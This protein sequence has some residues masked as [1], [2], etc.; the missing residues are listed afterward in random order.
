MTQKTTFCFWEAWVKTW[1]SKSE[2]VWG[3]TWPDLKRSWCD[4]ETWPNS[5]FLT[6]SFTYLAI[7]TQNT[8][9]WFWEA[10]VKTWVSK[11]E[12]VWGWTWPDPKKS[13][14]DLE[15]WPTS[16]F[17]NR[18][19][20]YLATV[21]QKATF[22][23][24]RVIVVYAM[25]HPWL[26]LQTIWMDIQKT[27]FTQRF[28]TN[29]HYYCKYRL[30]FKVAYIWKCQLWSLL[31]L[32]HTEYSFGGKPAKRVLSTSLLN[33]YI[34]ILKSYLQYLIVEICITPILQ[35]KLC[36]SLKRSL[37]V[38]LSERKLFCVLFTLCMLVSSQA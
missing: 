1:V 29:W 20:T 18:S 28:F 5:V 7:V 11:S 38:C 8:T 25:L 22:Y 26:S 9:L 10:W 21:T 32:E 13:W 15:T 33:Y 12:S 34:H 17:V 19:M 37:G 30:H 35:W 24:W 16:I 36:W 2:S 6:G 31:R 14:C 23:L 3:W 27:L 4:L